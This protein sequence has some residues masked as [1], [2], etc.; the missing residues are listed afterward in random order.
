MPDLSV[1]ICGLGRRMEVVVVPLGELGNPTL[2]GLLN[3]VE[4]KLGCKAE[5]IKADVLRELDDTSPVEESI[6]SLLAF[7][8]PLKVCAALSER[9]DWD[10]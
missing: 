2:G 8:Y 4:S 5:R 3:H 6:S 7:S 1:R 10:S 9:S